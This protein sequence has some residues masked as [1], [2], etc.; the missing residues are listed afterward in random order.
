VICITEGEE[1][2]LLTRILKSGDK[3]IATDYRPHPKGQGLGLDIKVSALMNLTSTHFIR[4]HSSWQTPS[5]LV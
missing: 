4:R 2:H 5:E 3:M 1:R